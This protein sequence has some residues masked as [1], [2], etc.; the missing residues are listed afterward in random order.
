MKQKNNIP[1]YK[2]PEDYFKDFEEQLFSKV[3]EE[4]LPK[5]NGF[6]VPK[7][8]FEAYEERILDA[9]T[10]SEKPT[11]TIS[12]FPKKYFSYA[13][14]IAACMIIGLSIFNTATERQNLDTLQWS[15][16]DTYIEEGNLNLDLYELTTMLEY[17]DISGVGNENWE[18]S[19]DDLEEYLFED[20]DSEPLIEEP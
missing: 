9:V 17:S 4:K 12:L 1:H 13:A 8:Y 19:Q 20:I 16:V 14:A 5:I 10:V 15:A 2:V 7:G 11:K 6:S 18:I 3:L